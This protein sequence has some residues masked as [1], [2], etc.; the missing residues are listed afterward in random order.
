[1]PLC[2]FLQQAVTKLNFSCKNWM[3]EF[4][5]IFYFIQVKFNYY[6]ATLDLNMG[7]V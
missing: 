4:M 5:H 7:N 1:M 6:L 3:L 2:T